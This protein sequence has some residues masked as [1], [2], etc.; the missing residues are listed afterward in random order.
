M[1]VQYCTNSN[2]ISVPI[3][4]ESARFLGTGWTSLFEASAKGGPDISPKTINKFLA[5]A[6]DNNNCGR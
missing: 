3:A 5:E 6:N 1:I 4:L 2:L